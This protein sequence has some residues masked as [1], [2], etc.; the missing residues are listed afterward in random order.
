M[1]MKS[2]QGTPYETK[3]VGGEPRLVIAGRPV[4]VTLTPDGRYRSH[5][6]F[7]AYDSLDQI[8]K[9]LIKFDPDLKDTSTLAASLERKGRSSVGRN[10]MRA[11]EKRQARRSGGGRTRAQAAPVLFGIAGLTAVDAAGLG[12]G[13]FGLLPGVFAKSGSLNVSSQ[14]GKRLLKAGPQKVNTYTYQVLSA[15]S[16]RFFGKAKALLEVTWQGNSW[17]EIQGAHVRRNLAQTTSW[18]KSSLNVNY[19]IIGQLPRKFKDPREWPIVFSYDGS[20]D[21]M[22]NGQYEFQGEFEINAFGGLKWRRH[23]V[24]SV[25]LAD[26]AIGGNPKD[27]VTRGA[28]RAYTV[29]KLPAAQRALLMKNLKALGKVP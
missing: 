12:L 29:P 5:D 20:F 17:G 21:P 26:W 16:P 11:V 8:A 10:R 15:V 9:Q 27:A 18:D 7:P 24:K 3:N 25:S 19:R 14:Q 6:L 23:D 28:D 4:H 2:F 13:V 22:G 1:A